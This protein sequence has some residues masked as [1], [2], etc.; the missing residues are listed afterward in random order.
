M[1]D[2]SWVLGRARMSFTN[3]AKPVTLVTK[4]G[5]SASLPDLIKDVTPPC[6]LNPLL[7]NGHL[8]TAYTGWIALLP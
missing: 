2:L 6:H 8:Q 5:Q 4:S 7:F 3:H 1:M